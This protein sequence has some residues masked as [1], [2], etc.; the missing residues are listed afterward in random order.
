MCIVLSLLTSTSIFFLF[1]AFVVIVSSSR[2]VLVEEVSLFLLGGFN[3][4]FDDLLLVISKCISCEYTKKYILLK[5]II[6]ECSQ[7]A[8]LE[9]E[10]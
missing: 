9:R 2:I 5:E 8:A 3:S 10:I 1:F 7:K 4:G 6:F